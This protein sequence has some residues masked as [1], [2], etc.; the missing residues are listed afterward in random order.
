MLVRRAFYVGA[1]GETLG[2]AD[3]LELGHA[4]DVVSV[5]VSRAVGSGRV[6]DGIAK[7]LTD[8]FARFVLK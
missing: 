3:G 4:D 7:N 6:P 8:T 5:A 2:E 1:L